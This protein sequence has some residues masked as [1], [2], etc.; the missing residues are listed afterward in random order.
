MDEVEAVAA[1]GNNAENLVSFN[2]LEDKVNIL[3]FADYRIML[4]A[5]V[6]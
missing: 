3:L 2:I 1:R 4:L 6:G 5:S